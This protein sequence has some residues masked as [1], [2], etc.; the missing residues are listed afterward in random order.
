MKRKAFTL[1]E[2]IVVI[3]IIGIIA[4]MVV[5]AVHKVSS[6]RS[7]TSTDT[8]GQTQSPLNEKVAPPAAAPIAGAVQ[9][10][11]NNAAD[12]APIK[13]ALEHAGYKVEP[14]TD[15]INL[16]YKP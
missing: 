14:V 9:F 5:G 8:S 2:L 3:A 4:A 10:Q 1:I 13:A 11:V 7:G 12:A 6:R 15:K 16:V